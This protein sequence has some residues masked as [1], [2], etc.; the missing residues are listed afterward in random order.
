MTSFELEKSFL[1]R[2]VSTILYFHGEGKQY[3]ISSYVDIRQMIH[4]KLQSHFSKPN[5]DLLTRSETHFCCLYRNS[6][7]ILAED[8]SLV[9]AS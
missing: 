6:K 3:N 7:K 2:L 1:F 5:V 9:I 4:T 8:R